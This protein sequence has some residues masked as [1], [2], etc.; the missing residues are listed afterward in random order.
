MYASYAPATVTEAEQNE[1]QAPIST[2][3]IVMLCGI[4]AT[5]A[6]PSTGVLTTA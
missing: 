6:L 2:L 5:I 4:G 3:S 1:E